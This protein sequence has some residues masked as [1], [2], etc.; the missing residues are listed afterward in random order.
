MQSALYAIARPSVLCMC[1]VVDD[2]GWPRTAI[3]SNFL[4]ILRLTVWLWRMQ[5][6]GG[7]LV[8]CVLNIK[9]VARLPLLLMHYPFKHVY[10]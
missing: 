6:W 3:S 8:S 4:G 1:G 10:G 9:A 7:D 5:D 2:L